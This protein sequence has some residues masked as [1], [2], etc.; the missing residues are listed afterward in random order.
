MKRQRS[1]AYPYYSIS[2]CLE[3]CSKIYKNLGTYR[4]TRQEI[5]KV[6]EVHVG[7]LSQKLGTCGQYGFIDVKPKEG[8]MTSD[9][10]LKWYRPVNESQGMDVKLEAFKNPP[11]YSSLIESFENNILPPVLALSNILFQKHNISEAACEKAASTFIE[12]ANELNIITGEGMLILSSSEIFAEDEIEDEYDKS[13]EIETDKV[14]VY[15]SVI[16]GKTDLKTIV[17]NQKDNK[18][19][20]NANAGAIPNSSGVV[21]PILLK[22]RRTAHLG[23]PNDAKSEDLDTIINWIRL[24]K[25]SF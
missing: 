12:N 11:L 4:A 18:R 5:A 6:L 2:Y 25:E 20:Q 7:T 8:Y 9:L 23:L 19:F 17:E 21:I 15:E 24:M 16:K 13:N 3:F 14:E 1:A 22:E 10:F